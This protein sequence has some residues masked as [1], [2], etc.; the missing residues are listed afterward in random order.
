MAKGSKF[1]DFLNRV[2]Y[3]DG[4]KT[5]TEGVEVT[6]EDV[7]EFEASMVAEGGEDVVAMAQKIIVDS[8]MESDNDEF[9]DISNVQSV[10]DTAGADASHDLVRKIL[11][12]FVHCEPADL[13]KDGIARRQAILN[14]IEQTKQQAA[15]LRTEK[16]DEEQNLAQ[17]EKDAEAACTAA[18]SQANMDSEAAIQAEKERSAAVIAEIRRATDEATEAAKQQRDATLEEIANKRSENDAALQKS[19]SLVAETEKQGQMVIGQIDNWL[20]YLQ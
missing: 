3:E 2:F 14:A 11:T 16:A 7:A 20:N 12:N 18:I 15:A 10:L 6:P 8:Q 5:V 9:P 17:A 1:A 4:G 13:E 19:A